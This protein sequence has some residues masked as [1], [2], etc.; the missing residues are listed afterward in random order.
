MIDRDVSEIMMQ[1]AKGGYSV[2]PQ[3]N[4]RWLRVERL[5]LQAATEKVLVQA[6]ADA[7]E[8]AKSTNFRHGNGTN[9]LDINN[10]RNKRLMLMTAQYMRHEALAE[11]WRWVERVQVLSA[12][13]SSGVTNSTLL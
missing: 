7:E 10:D 2:S 11:L 1:R 5:W 9:T 4:L 8:P 13:P 3:H 6:Q 12:Q